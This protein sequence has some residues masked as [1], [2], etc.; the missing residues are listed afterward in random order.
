MKKISLI[1]FK[2]LVLL[3]FIFQRIFKKSFM[4]H[5]KDFFMRIAYKKTDFEKSIKFFIPNKVVEWR[6]DTKKKEPET[7]EWINF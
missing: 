4:S 6:V 7:L 5:I 2:I 3:D 1:I